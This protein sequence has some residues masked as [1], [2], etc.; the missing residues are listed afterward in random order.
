MNASVAPARPPGRYDGAMPVFVRWLL[1]LGPLNPIAVRLVQNGSRRMRHNIIRSA[2][3]AVLVIVLLWS[4]LYHGGKGEM[5]FS[6]LA[7]AGAA[8]FEWVAYLQIGLICVLAPVFMAGAI[9]QEA[10]P[11]TWEVLLTTP[12]SAAQIVLGN[13][14]GRLFFILA[15]LM[16][17]LPLFAITQ[18]FGGVPGRAILLSYLVAGCAALVVGSI[19]IA[20]A[21]SRVVGKR[22]VFAFYVSVVSYLAATYAIDAFL[23]SRGMGASGGNGVTF[24]TALNPFLTLNSLLNPSAYPAAPAGSQL[25]LGRW[26]LERPVATYA[27]IAAGLSAFLMLVSI[28]TVRLGG[29]GQIT[30]DSTGVPWYRKVF[31]LGAAKAEHRAPRTV[32]PNPIAWREATARNATLGRIAA[33]WAF[34]ALGGLFGLGLILAYHFQWLDHAGFRF[35]LSATVIGELIVLTLVAINMSATAVTREREDGT[36]DLLLTTP[37]TPAKYLTG[38]L[39]GL[40]A[41]LLPMLMVPLGTL[42][43]SGLYVAFNGFGRTNGI[44]TPLALAGPTNLTPGLNVPPA[45]APAATIMMPVTLP[46]AALLAPLA[47]IPFVAFCVMIG[48][49]QSLKSRGTLASVVSSVAIVAVTAGMVGLCG[50]QSAAR[51]P[52]AGPVLAAMSPASLVHSLISPGEAM[53]GTIESAQ[54]LGAARL[55]LAAGCVVA[56]GLYAALVYGLHSTLVRSFD[57]IVR[58]LAGVK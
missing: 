10:S 2:Y 48:L 9:E 23:R 6:E 12:M 30:T 22:A 44:S 57:T 58:R 1:T 7:A 13:L 19:A 36:L 18:Y 21:V 25:G 17:S 38:K 43:L 47:V 29:L 14:L 51:I 40:I 42:M 55:S 34:V 8:S 35:A 37:I 11:Q 4:M 32:G 49:Q 41:Y 24:L 46:E 3:L 39:K 52:F 16:A 45:A 20:L 50:W 27:Y 31:G 33:R 26:F 54:G 56:A 15:L 53:G 28:V 5:P